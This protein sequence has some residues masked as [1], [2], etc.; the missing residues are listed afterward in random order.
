MAPM[1]NRVAYQ[2]ARRN[3]NAPEKWGRELSS[4]AEDIPNTPDR[5]QKFPLKWA[6]DFFPQPAHEH[7]DDVRLRIEVVFPHVRQDHSLR[8][9]LTGIAHQVLEQR[10]FARPQIDR[11]AI[12]RDAARQKIEYQILDRQRG[13]LGRAAGSPHERLHA[14]E[15]LCESK[16][17]GQVI[18]AACL[19][20]LHA[21]VD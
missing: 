12:S 18:V 13:R 9:D 15:E 8:D 2:T 10:E 3:P 17:F 11:L 20:A 5:V 19:Q 7:V 6:I 1:T 16:R 4:P 21:V 14:S